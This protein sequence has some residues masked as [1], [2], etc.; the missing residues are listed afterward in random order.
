MPLWRNW[1]ADNHGATM[2]ITI[3]LFSKLYW[4]WRTLSLN[5]LLGRE[6]WYRKGASQV[7]GSILCIAI[8]RLCE[9]QVH[10]LKRNKNDDNNNN[11][12]NQINNYNK[13]NVN[14][15][16]TT[17]ATT[18]NNIITI[19]MKI[20]NSVLINRLMFTCSFV[21]L[22][23]TSCFFSPIMNEALKQI[24]VGFKQSM[25]VRWRFP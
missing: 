1:W 24:N 15:N 5:P 18:N 3:F 22:Q 20:L 7:H 14:D 6:T 10:L 19:I 13:Y 4:L 9:Q 12:N 25:E 2:R 8:Q 23:K 16:T 21:L 17:T 11:Y